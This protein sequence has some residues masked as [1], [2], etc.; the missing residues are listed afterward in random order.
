MAFDKNA[1]VRYSARC[2]WREPAGELQ[3]IR[4]LGWIHVWTV[5]AANHRVLETGSMGGRIT[6]TMD[7]GIHSMREVVVYERSI[8][9]SVGGCVG[10]SRQGNLALAP[11]EC[12][13]TCTLLFLVVDSIDMIHAPRGKAQILSRS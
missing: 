9:R 7:D 10:F 3:G 1:M 2:L 5:W 12:P 8:G 4:A 6:A 13:S 11:P